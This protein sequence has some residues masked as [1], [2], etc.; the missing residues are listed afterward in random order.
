M[1]SRSRAGGCLIREILAYDVLWAL[2]GSLVPCPPELNS[3]GTEQNSSS[4]FYSLDLS[5]RLLRLY[6][7]T[8]YEKFYAVYL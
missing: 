8:G 6:L 7:V 4:Y 5:D 1:G 3:I 2:L